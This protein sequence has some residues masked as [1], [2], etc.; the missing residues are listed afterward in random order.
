MSCLRQEEEFRQYSKMLPGSGVRASSSRNE[1]DLTYAEVNRQIVLIVNVLV[2]VFACGAALWFIARHWSVPQRLSLSL[3]G[4]ITVGVAEVVIYA[5][6]LERVRR[7]KVEEQTRREKKEVLE[8]WVLEKTDEQAV[9]SLE[10]DER[11]RRR[12]PGLHGKDNEVF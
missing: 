1:D 4:G 6:Y 12:L 2:S 5:G 10:R 7:A 3:T 9:P 8:T 11:L